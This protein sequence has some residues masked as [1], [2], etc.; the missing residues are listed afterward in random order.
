MC[1]GLPPP[2]RR[3]LGSPLTLM[4]ARILPMLKPALWLGMAQGSPVTSRNTASSSSSSF[5]SRV[6]ASSCCMKALLL[7]CWRSSRTAVPSNGGIAR[8]ETGMMGRGGLVA[9]CCCDASR[10]LRAKA[11][12][13]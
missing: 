13:E 2:L 10:L 6:R 3:C 5:A 8:A 9:R 4:M 7:A 1:A 11:M 12:C